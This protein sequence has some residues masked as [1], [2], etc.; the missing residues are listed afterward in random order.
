MSYD[1]VGEHAAGYTRT[2]F[3]FRD[4]HIVLQQFLYI[5]CLSAEC[6]LTD[7]V[8]IISSSRRNNAAAG[9]T[10]LLYFDGKSF[11]QYLEGEADVLERLRLTILADRRHQDIRIILEGRMTARQFPNWRM[12]F[13]YR[14]T[15]PLLSRLNELRGE[16]ALAELMRFQGL[17]D[18]E[19]L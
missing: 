10:G 12:G 9:I 5:S 7:V 3:A 18:F 19:F 4:E 8:R 14:D 13:A 2:H 16:E 1:I 15:T 6:L 17:S 11:C